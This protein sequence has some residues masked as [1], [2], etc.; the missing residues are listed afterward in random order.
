MERATR[1]AALCPILLIYWEPCDKGYYACR[2]FFCDHAKEFT[3]PPIFWVSIYIKQIVETVIWVLIV[4][5]HFGSGVSKSRYDP[6][7]VFCSLL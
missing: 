7:D 4:G 2:R 1:L 5:A 3:L 6:G